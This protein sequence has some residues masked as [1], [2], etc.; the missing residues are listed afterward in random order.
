MTKH[1]VPPA[2]HQ[3]GAYNDSLEI[4]ERRESVRE[5]FHKLSDGVRRLNKKLITADVSPYPYQN[6]PPDRRSS[7]SSCHPRS[8]RFLCT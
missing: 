4:H 7:S 1:A 8:R 5:R 6:D 2:P 3:F